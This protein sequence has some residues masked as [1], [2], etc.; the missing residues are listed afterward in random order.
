MKKRKKLVFAL[1]IVMFSVIFSYLPNVYASDY[2]TNSKNSINTYIK[3]IL[4]FLPIIFL[5]CSIIIWYIYGRDDKVDDTIEF[6]PPEGFNSL[7]VGFLYKGRADM[8]DLV[9]LLIYLGNKGYIKIA[10]TIKETMTHSFRNIVKIT[11]IKDYDGNNTIEKELLESLMRCGR[12]DAEN[13]VTS[14]NLYNRYHFY[15]RDILDIMINCKE[16]KESIFEKVKWQ[17][18]AIIIMIIISYF[19][20][21][22]VPI[23]ETIGSNSISLGLIFSTILFTFFIIR[24]FDFTRE[25]TIYGNN[26]EGSISDISTIFLFGLASIPQLFF[27][28]K[29]RSNVFYLCIYII[30]MICIIGM[31]LCFF[32]LR[33]RTPYGKQMLKKTSGLRNFILTADKAKLES[34]VAQNP[35][36]FYDILP[37]AYAFGLSSKWIDNFENIPITAPCWYGSL[38]KFSFD[39]F[40]SFF[41]SSMS[42]LK[43]NMIYEDRD[44]D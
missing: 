11:Q 23:V 13:V 14:D 15:A 10:S 19:A 33:R 28:P 43:Y 12:V 5:I 35:N 17:K 22:I 40:R 24:L 20:I 7:E 2:T 31:T 36:Y 21:T 4:Y 44:W 37:Y 42:L 30:G 41:H 25:T 29:F 39:T 18:F 27:V 32:Y 1:F 6:Y 16:N 9:S 8:L 26:I 3:I 38:K 34:L